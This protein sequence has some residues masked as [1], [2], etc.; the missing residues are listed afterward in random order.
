MFSFF[1]LKGE[2]KAQGTVLVYGILVGVFVGMTL[3]HSI[4]S[5]LRLVRSRKKEGILLPFYGKLTMCKI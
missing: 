3:A 2:R 4:E 1:I 5:I